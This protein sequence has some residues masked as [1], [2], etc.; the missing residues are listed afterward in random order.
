MTKMR[1]TVAL[2]LGSVAAWSGLGTLH[3]AQHADSLLPVLVSLQRW[4]PFYWGQDRFG[5]LVPLLT[6]PIRHP[7]LNMLAQGWL[8]TWSAF[9]APFLVARFL[10]RRPAVWV[11]A[12]A[13]TNILL[14]VVASR[15]VRF[16]W[17][18]AQPYGAAIALGFAGLLVGESDTP[19]ARVVALALLLLAEWVNVTTVLVLAPALAVRGRAWSMPMAFCVGS[20]AVNAL[21]ARLVS[22]PHTITS[23]D[24]VSDWPHAWTT[25]AWSSASVIAR[26]RVAAAFI[27]AGAVGTIIAV[28]RGRRDVLL[29]VCA[30]L[31]V[32][33]ANWLAV[34]TSAWVHMNLYAPRYMFPSLLMFGVAITIPV[35]SA[36]GR[37]GGNALVGSLTAFAV[38][39]G[40]AYGSPSWQRLNR[41]IDH[42]FAAMSR[43][44]I[45]SSASV[46]AGDYWGVWPAVFHA[47]L[48]RYRATGKGRVYG[49]TVRSEATD[50]RWN[51]PGA[52][53]IIAAAPGDRTIGIYA[54]RAGLLLEH[55]ESRPAIELFLATASR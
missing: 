9:A 27:A 42:R 14:V 52:R 16:D 12:G 36:L 39:A 49:L 3:D 22:A 4:T 41:Q 24:V 28:F 10:N 45:S 40:V 35:G 19:S 34:G 46:I 23:L 1:V 25:L 32:G 47:N 21:L 44:V 53:V 29:S 31:A 8:T 43:D 6:L 55:I 50:V 5:M 38:I 51:K 33:A 18:V 48:A 7:L 20:L 37:G 13:L 54:D 2:L 11:T 17:L 15:D 30:A 26:P